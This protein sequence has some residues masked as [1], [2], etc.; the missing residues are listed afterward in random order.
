MVVQSRIRRV[1][2]R[3]LTLSEQFFLISFMILLGGMLLM[4]W[5]IANRIQTVVLDQ[6]ANVTALYMKSFV[7]PLLQPLT[8]HDTLNSAQHRELQR[9]VFNT[10]LG[11]DIVS[12]KVWS[13]EGKILFSLDPSLIGTQAPLT[14]ELRAAL[15]GQIIS[16]LTTLDKPQQ[17]IDNRFLSSLIATY[18]PVRETDSNR[19]IAVTEFYQYSEPL[20]R[21][22]ASAQ[23]QSWLVVTV[24]TMFMYALLS[25][26][27][28]RGSQT[29]ERQHTQLQQSVKDLEALLGENQR[30]QHG[31][32]TAAARITE[33]NEQFLHRIG[34]DLHDGPA[35]DIAL[36]L[37]R[38]DEVCQAN[39]THL[40]TIRHA[41]RSA[42]HEI[43]TL[44]AGLQL[45]ELE[46]LSVAEV[47][48][49]AVREFQRKT[50]SAPHFEIGELPVSL[51]LSKKIAVYRVITEGL[52]NAYRHA[53]SQ[54]L[55]V[56]MGTDRQQLN[57]DITD[58]GPGFDLAA[59]QSN[60]DHLGIAG[61]QQRIA[62]LAGVF[63]IESDQAA[64]THIHVTIPLKEG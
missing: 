43:R 26:L 18:V 15:D 1:L 5:W 34:R 47:A 24:A 20:L 17:T 25:G 6:T 37:L 16:H 36:A 56:R 41:L 23:Q 39:P 35:Q 61:L 54:D 2:K 3:R 12:L 64:G 11:Q 21:Q 13:P 27:V 29:I 9:L 8:T 53:G 57:I 32:Q 30:L 4:G 49:R 42:L 60:G 62:L 31:L 50:T 7:A 45:P 33:I 48:K 40:E 63:T 19:I 22:I 38:L 10:P 44:A 58:S 55:R 46:T 51:S 28:A 14:D 52:F 59:L